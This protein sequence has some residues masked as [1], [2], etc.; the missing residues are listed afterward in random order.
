MQPTAG[1]DGRRR[2]TAKQQPASEGITA[3]S[4][5]RC[6]FALNVVPLLQAGAPSNTFNLFFASLER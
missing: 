4:R 3:P 6:P 5:F 1:S 2:G